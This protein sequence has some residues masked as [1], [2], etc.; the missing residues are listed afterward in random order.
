M[1]NGAI[2]S[3]GLS[4]LPIGLGRLCLVALESLSEEQLKTDG[5]HRKESNKK[6]REELRL[7]LLEHYE[8]VASNDSKDDKKSNEAIAKVLKLW[9][10]Q[11]IVGTVKREIFGVYRHD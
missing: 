3:L 4:D 11:E 9:D 8:S 1:K 5:I 10:C 2:G 7:K 6:R